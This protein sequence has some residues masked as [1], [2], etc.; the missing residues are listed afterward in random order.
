[1]NGDTLKQGVPNMGLGVALLICSATLLGQGGQ[2]QPKPPK[3]VPSTQPDIVQGC[4]SIRH[5]VFHKSFWS[6]PYITG[7]ITN[8]CG[9]E[10]PVSIYSE[11]HRPTEQSYKDRYG[12]D[13]DCLC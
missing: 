13:Y 6:G 12:T 10:T 4:I 5:I 9:H 7:S 11:L 3:Q 2:K 1:L 8:T